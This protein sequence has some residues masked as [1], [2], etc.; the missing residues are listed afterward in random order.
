MISL[1]KQTTAKTAKV[2][3]KEGKWVIKGG[4]EINISE[5]SD[6]HLKRSIKFAKFMSEKLYKESIFFA[7][8]LDEMEKTLNNRQRK[9]VVE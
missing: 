1:K 3:E 5:M 9:S 7:C 8:K 4:E 6:V 2:D